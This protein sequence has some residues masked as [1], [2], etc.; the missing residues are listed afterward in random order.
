MRM[1]TGAWRWQDVA[2]STLGAGSLTDTA[3]CILEPMTAPWR[4]VGWRLEVEALKNIASDATAATDGLETGISRHRG[5][6][7]LGNA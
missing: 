3:D 2:T 4:D 1:H 6:P 7:P 5:M